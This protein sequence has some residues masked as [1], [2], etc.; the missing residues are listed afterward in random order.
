M[1][2]LLKISTFNQSFT[3]FFVSWRGM[4]FMQMPLHPFA[5]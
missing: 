3:L 4:P 1:K 5:E 2:D